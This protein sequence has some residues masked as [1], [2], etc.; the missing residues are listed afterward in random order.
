MRF[1]LP[2]LLFAPSALL[3]HPGHD[4]GDSFASGLAHPLLGLD[5]L[6]AMLAIGVLA[7]L[8]G[9]HARWAVPGSFLGG[10]LLFGILGVGGAESVLA[11]HMI[12]ASLIILGA[13]MALAV[14]P[15]VAMIATFATVF[16]AAHGYAHGSE[17]TGDGGYLLGFMLSTAA[18]HGA[19]FALG[20][21]VATRGP[22]LMR[23]SGG[24]VLLSGVVL[25]FF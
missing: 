15:P 24:V 1:L 2:I 13:A 20:A 10:M 9:G 21:W 7:A 6:V 23:G 16:G 18:L 8:L 12:I 3:A 4:H 5:H 22:W 17:G 25:T 11:E 14:R 19:G